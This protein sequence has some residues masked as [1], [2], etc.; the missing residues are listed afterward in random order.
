MTAVEL[1]PT[2]I[3]GGDKANMQN[4]ITPQAVHDENLIELIEENLGGTQIT[5]SILP[6]ISVPAGGGTVWDFGDDGAKSIQGV[7]I[8]VNPERLYWGARYG[9]QNPDNDQPY[10]HSDDTITGVA[11]KEDDEYR[12]VGKGNP[13]GGE[14]AICPQAEWG[15][16]DIIRNSQACTELRK[17][18]VLTSG[19]IIPYIL[20]IPSGSLQAFNKFIIDS[21][22]KGGAL[23]RTVTEFSLDVVESDGVRYS[24]VVCRVKEALPASTA[25]DVKDYA[26]EF[27]GAIAKTDRRQTA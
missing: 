10:C 6:R 21:L 14:C 19:D 15:S 26:K 13:Y 2:T 16:G 5:E 1:M 12:T 20:N 18:Y 23:Y 17:L 25:Q 4:F 22:N 24:Q 27:I 9:E 7:I 11:I 3:E 8:A